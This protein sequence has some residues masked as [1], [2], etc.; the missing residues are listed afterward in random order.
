MPN[1]DEIKARRKK[2]PNTPWH[3][4]QWGMYIWQ[5]EQAEEGYAIADTHSADSAGGIVA[6]RGWGYLREKY[7]EEKA[8]QIQK[9]TAHFIANAPTDIDWLIQEVERLMEERKCLIES[10]AKSERFIIVQLGYALGW[11]KNADLELARQEIGVTTMDDYLS[12][13]AGDHT[14]E[15]LALTVRKKLQEHPHD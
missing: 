7:G 9:D 1:L 14:A 4:D 13:V 6:V 5:T 8:E 10:F 3:T 15:T 11:D 2:V 12:C